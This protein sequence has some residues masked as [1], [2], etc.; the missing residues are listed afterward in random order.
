MIALWAAFFGVLA[1]DLTARSGS[2]GAALGFHMAN[3]VVA[4]LI[5][6]VGGTLDGLALWSLPIDLTDPAVARPA[7]I[8]DFATMIVSWLLARL[9]LR[10]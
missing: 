2:L 5:I 6:G 7:L 8:V 4:L 9:A 10:V 1:A 3:N